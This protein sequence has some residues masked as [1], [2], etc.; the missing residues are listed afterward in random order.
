MQVIAEENS[1]KTKRVD[2]CFTGMLEEWL[3]S[4]P[5]LEDLFT[6]LESPF[7]RRADI[8]KDLKGNIASKELVL[9]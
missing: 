9:W 6:A 1:G 8:A 3:K 7:I 2:N 5:Q 4:G